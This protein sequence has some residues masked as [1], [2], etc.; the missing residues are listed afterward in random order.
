MQPSKN[1]TS[2]A[3]QRRIMYMMK[4]PATAN[5]V[6][7]HLEDVRQDPKIMEQFKVSISVQCFLVIVVIDKLARWIVESGD[8]LLHSLRLYNNPYPELN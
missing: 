4:N 7:L 5:S 6:A 3:C 8:S 1:K 2:R